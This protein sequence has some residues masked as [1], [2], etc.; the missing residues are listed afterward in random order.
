MS[1]VRPHFAIGYSGGYT[2]VLIYRHVDRTGWL[3]DKVVC[4]LWDGDMREAAHRMLSRPDWLVWIYAMLRKNYW[5]RK[6]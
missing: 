1:K 3:T 5:W 4:D 6:P 2:P